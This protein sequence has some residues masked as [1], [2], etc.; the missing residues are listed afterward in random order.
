LE[1]ARSE[2]F[3][4]AIATLWKT[5]FE[6]P[7]VEATHYVYF[8]QSIESRFFR[9]SRRADRQRV[10]S[11]YTLPVHYVTEA[12][13]IQEHL[14]EHYGHRAGLVRNGIRKDIFYTQHLRTLS[15][16]TQPRIL[17][18]GPFRIWFK[19]TAMAIEIARQAGAKE[20]TVL[21]STPIHWLPGVQRLHSSVPFEEVGEIYR[22]CDILLK[23]STVEG[24][25]G[26]PLEMFHCGGTAIVFDV[27]GHEEYIRDGEN[28]LVVESGR[29]DKAFEALQELLHDRDKLAFLRKNALKTA[30]EW[31]SWSESS[32]EFRQWIEGLQHQPKSE[33]RRIAALVEQ[34]NA[35][36]REEESQQLQ[37]SPLKTLQAPVLEALQ[38]TSPNFKAVA[39]TMNAIVELTTARFKLTRSSKH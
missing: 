27:S 32:E 20:M 21:T 37:R 33:R 19:N 14:K 9:E 2:V 23:L 36:F 34:I 31:P 6:L 26:P 15:E 25:F 29:Y 4:V 1:K 24:M 18:E 22:S 12:S 17:V 8:V 10:D 35:R 38:K 3:D 13:W 16:D 28:A 5:A 11:T 39:E 30:E 7:T